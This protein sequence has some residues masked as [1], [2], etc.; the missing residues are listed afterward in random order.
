VRAGHVQLKTI[1]DWFQNPGCVNEVRDR[2]A[3]YRDEKELIRGD[4]DRIQFRPKRDCAGI[5]EADGINVASVGVLSE[6]WF[7]I[8]SSGA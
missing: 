1:G 3:K 5:R 2:G 4:V 7:A 8:S 6:N